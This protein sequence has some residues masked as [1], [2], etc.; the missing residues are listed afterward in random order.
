MGC[1]APSTPQPSA[2]QAGVWFVTKSAPGHRET[3]NPALRGW[4]CSRICIHCFL[5]LPC[6][7]RMA[8]KIQGCLE[9]ENLGFG[10]AVSSRRAYKAPDSCHGCRKHSCYPSAW[11]RITPVTDATSSPLSH[12]MGCTGP[13]FPRELLSQPLQPLLLA[14]WRVQ[15]GPDRGAA[16]TGNVVVQLTLKCETTASVLLFQPFLGKK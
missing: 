9:L 10:H 15:E 12:P 1:A 11:L 2:L 16:V 3:L 8:G 6:F 13:V 4:H 14:H 7:K 5:A